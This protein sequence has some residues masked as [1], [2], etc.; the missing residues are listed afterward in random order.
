M[1]VT[2]RSLVDTSVVARMD[3][4]DVSQRLDPLIRCGLVSPV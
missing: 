2:T 3:K 1:A 4:P